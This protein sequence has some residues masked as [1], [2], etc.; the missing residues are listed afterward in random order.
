VR[1]DPTQGAEIGKTR[2]AIVVTSP[3]I[4]RLPL[5]VV[6]PITGW[7]SAFE[8]FPWMIKIDPTPQNNLAKPSAADA[9]QIKSLSIV[10]F[11]SRIG[12]V[13]DKQLVEITKAI[14]L[15]VGYNL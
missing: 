6:I 14:A 1:F 7:Q 5:H 9:F 10:R 15:V 4:G 2:P 8:V 3:G 13:A 11:E 12:V